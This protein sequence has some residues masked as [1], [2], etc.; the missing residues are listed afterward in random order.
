[1]CAGTQGIGT[2]AIYQ[3]DL[4]CKITDMAPSPHSGAAGRITEALRDADAPLGVADLVGATGL[5]ENA[6]RR[7]LARLVTDGRVHAEE[8]PAGGRRGRPRRLHR[9]VD[10]P[11]R[12][13]RE[14]LSLVLGLLAGG[15]GDGHGAAFDAG[16]AHGRA[17]AARGTATEAVTGALAELGFSPSRRGDG[18]GGI[19]LEACPFADQVLGPGGRTLCSLHHG[20]VAGV[21]EARGGAITSFEAADPSRAPCTLAVRDAPEGAQA[22]GN[23]A[24]IARKASPRST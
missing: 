4:C 3:H 16:R 19:A 22:G 23:P 1:M 20:I 9:A 6:V 13:Y 17:A 11:E 2:W 14:L 7:A 21:A 5:H 10:G 15:R 12:P 8:A 18:E 24:T